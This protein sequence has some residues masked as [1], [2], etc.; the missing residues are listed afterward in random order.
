[1][2]YITKS[3]FYKRKRLSKVKKIKNL[4]KQSKRETIIKLCLILILSTLYILFVIN[5]FH[6]SKK[7]IPYDGRIF[8]C[9]LYNNEAETAYIHIWRLYHYIDKFIFVISNITHSGQPRN[10]TFK[11]FEENIKPYMDK[12][13]IVYYNDGCITNRYPQYHLF[14]CIENCQRDFAKTYIEE[15]YDPTEK[16]LL[17]VVDIDEI[18]TREG[19]EYIIKNP[20]KDLYYLYGVMYFPY[21]YHRF[22]NWYKG[23]AI[24]YKK[25]MR[26]LSQIRLS[27]ISEGNILRFPFNSL[28]PL[29]T[30]C[31]Y[32]YKNIEDYRNKLASFM[33]SELNKFPYNT[34]DWIFKSHYCRIKIGSPP[35]GYDEPYEGWK[36]LIPNDKRLKFIVDRSFIYDIKKTKYTEK[37]LETLC[38]KKFNRTPFEP[39]TKYKA[40]Y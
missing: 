8:L 21:Y 33:H 17:I 29:I 15:H 2:K 35:N 34:N 32:C 39:S 1:M 37:D 24:R 28:K 5:I 4:A 36:H 16:D 30:H 14:W 20:P 6:T 25:N 18:L 7:I 9:T 10:F 12:I 22:D 40:W 27:Q 11:P 23:Y 19:I 13:D 31:S 3:K 26:P 38:Y